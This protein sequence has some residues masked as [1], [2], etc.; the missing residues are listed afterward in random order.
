MIK[1]HILATL[2]VISLALISCSQEVVL[3]EELPQ[4]FPDYIGVTV[5]AGIAPL[6]FDLSEEY[7][8]VF[9]V[10]SDSH[11]NS[12][13]AKGAYAGFNVKKWHKLT[14]ANVGG[15]LTVRV[16][17]YKSGKWEQFIPFMIFVSKYRLD[18]YGVTY[19]KFAPG[20]ET[21]SKIGIYQRNIH[22]FNEEPIVEGTL[23]P[24]QCMGCHT[25]NATSADE[26][27]FHLRGK[28]GATVVQKA[29]K[30]KWLE[31]KT[32]MT[33][34]R[35]A[36]SYWHPSGEYITH[37]NNLVHQLFWTGN[38]D[39]YIEVYDE[40]SDVI[41]HDVDNDQFIL[42]PNLMTA[43]FETYPAFSSDGETL[44]YC[45]APKVQVPAQ[46]QD[47]HYNLCAVAFDPQTGKVGNQVDTLIHAS[48]MG[49]SVTLPRPSYDGRWILY[50]YAD[51]GCF[52]INHKE[53]D[54]WLLDLQDGSTHPLEKAN[55]AYC[56][57]FHNWSSNSRWI[58]FSSRRGD[59]LYSR[60]YIAEIDEDGNA[61]KPFLLPQKDPSFYH[62]TLFTFNVPDFT[63]G[64]VDFKTSKAY[65]EAFSDKRTNITVK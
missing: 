65:K 6:N 29:G 31:T 27:L 8:K 15:T 22:D 62:K 44:F 25:A 40:A 38:N 11:G 17:G 26:F 51:F 57:S 5:P 39:R 58:L 34:G 64:K 18:D 36:Y 42:S 12:I 35:T 43:D 59:N 49:K 19:R 14:E 41:V 33:I 47:L 45:S 21:Y 10:V 52:P 16:A 30:R 50:S 3:R 9:A 55:S 32:D 56:E 20:Y 61:S 4:I 1:K 28:H 37:S 46:A 48:E 63:K 53:S 24:G 7:T 13:K 54:L 2:T 60:I 23:L